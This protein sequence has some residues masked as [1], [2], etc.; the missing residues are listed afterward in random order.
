MVI[1]SENSD[2]IIK[3]K[4]LN[5]PVAL[6][7]IVTKSKESFSFLIS[8]F[9]HFHYHVMIVVHSVITNDLEN[10]DR[11]NHE[12]REPLQFVHFI[13]AWIKFV[14]KWLQSPR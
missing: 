12:I 11:V 9:N 2:L 7:E 13:G 8:P 6:T 4:V 5:L 3:N 14:I 10:Q 1:N